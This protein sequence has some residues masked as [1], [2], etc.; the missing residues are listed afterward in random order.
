MP[1]PISFIIR[2]KWP[3]RVWENITMK[4][5][6]VIRSSDNNR[7]VLD[8]GIQYRKGQLSHK[9]IRREQITDNS[10]KRPFP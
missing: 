10:F 2:N 1:Q 6:T 9:T 4:L 8:I 5:S 3:E 7:A